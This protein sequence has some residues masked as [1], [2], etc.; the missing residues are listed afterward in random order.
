[1]CRTL[2]LPHHRQVHM[3]EP[4]I[5]FPHKVTRT[6]KF[7]VCIRQNLNMAETISLQDKLISLKPKYLCFIFNDRGIKYKVGFFRSHHM[8]ILFQWGFFCILAG[9]NPHDPALEEKLD[10]TCS[11]PTELSVIPQSFV[12][13]FLFGIPTIS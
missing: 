7:L 3:D 11:V 6:F 4:R 12:P 9:T 1:M 13:N 5:R 2:F 10:L 8:R